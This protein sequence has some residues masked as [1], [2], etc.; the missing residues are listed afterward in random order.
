MGV[1]G[2]LVGGVWSLISTRHGIV[3]GFQGLS[4]R[5]RSQGGERVRTDQDMSLT[6]M[7]TIL[8]IVLS[9][10]IG[11]YYSL[12][13]TWGLTIVT[14]IAMIVASFFF[15]AVS[16]YI[17][18]LV[19]SSKNPVSGM[20]ICAVMGTAAFLLA[21]GMAGESA[22]IATLG[23]A[24]V[25]CCA[26][27]MAGDCSQ[28]LK[29]GQLIGATP[30]KQQWAEIIAIV[31]CCCVMAP[32]LTMLHAAYGIG[33]GLKA[34]QATLFASIASAF[35]GGTPLPFN[36]VYIGMG[37]GVALII[38]NNWLEKRG[39]AF[40]T[41]VMP[42][43]IGLYL[44]LTLSIPVFLGGVVRASVDAA[45]KRRGKEVSEAEDHGLLLSSGFIAGEAIMG[46]L[47]AILITLKWS[48]A[49][50]VA[51]VSNALSTGL[52]L[53]AMVAVMALLRRQALK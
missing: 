37:I 51:A 33:T 43:S 13:H 27:C 30:W 14:S 15:V 19:G 24:G 5:Y 32:V 4:G 8:G 45:R 44:P 7:G 20:T 26:A 18:G 28:D 46:I 17:V 49:I 53:A 1:G 34:P 47:I 3:R 22:I 23:V 6:A 42:V 50:K 31:A 48:D 16:S 21:L 25:V 2:M 35:F 11:L 41:Y 52:A 12:L 29:T 36:M 38:I 9:V 40:R 39:Y 10:L